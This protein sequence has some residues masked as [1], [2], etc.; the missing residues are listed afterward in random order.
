MNE[1]EFFYEDNLARLIRATFDPSARPDAQLRQRGWENVKSIWEAEHVSAKEQTINNNR[2]NTFMSQLFNK[3]WGFGLGAL[4]VAAIAVILLAVFYPQAQSKAAVVMSQGARVIANLTS[5]HLHGQMRTLPHDNFSLIAAEIDFCPI[6]LWKE[7]S[8][9]VKWRIEKP[10]RVAVMDGQTTVLY[11]KHLNQG[12]KISKA[13]SS[14][15]D[16]GWLQQIADLSGNLE[17]ELQHVKSYGWKMD[18][19]E[20][21]GIDGKPKSIVTIYAKPIF[22]KYE[23][24]YIDTA[25]TR[26]VYLFDVQSERLESVQIF[27]VFTNHETLVFNLNQ[28]DYNQTIAPAIWK[29]DLPDDVDWNFGKKNIPILPDNEKYVNMTPEEAA[30]DFFEA[31]GRKDWDEAYKFTDNFPRKIKERMKDDLGGLEV[32]NIGQHF[33]GK[34]SGL[35]YPGVYVP[36]EIKL[37]SGETKKFNLAIRNDNPAKRWQV[38][39]GL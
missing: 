4:G 15:F 19:S 11:L 36:Y 16:T 17:K 38:D 27:Q 2:K 14:P 20:G 23:G 39:G 25:D 32:V 7:F 37:P 9:T 29:L 5:I 35:L 26:R 3:R 31:C 33:K 24:A 21:T 34:I 8:P 18:Y 13:L 28:I 30:R 12:T 1:Q 10:G 6:E 22:H